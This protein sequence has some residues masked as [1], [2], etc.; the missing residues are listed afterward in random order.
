MNKKISVITKSN[1]NKFNKTIS[2]I[3][4]CKSSSFRALTFASQAIGISYLKGVLESDDTKC[5]IQSLK[6]LGVKI[7]KIKPGEYKIYGNGENS[8]VQPKKKQLYFGNAGTLGILM[9]FL[10]TNSNIKCR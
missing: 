8:Y 6:K 3:P 7:I 4:G 9:G 5:C 10:A 2:T 1:I